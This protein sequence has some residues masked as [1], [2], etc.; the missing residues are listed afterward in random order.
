MET[1][2]GLL[3]QALRFLLGI[4]ILA[5]SYLNL[6]CTNLVVGLLIS[7]FFFGTGG[8]GY[9]PIHHYFGKI[10]KKSKKSRKKGKT[11]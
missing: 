4:A 11:I 9:C 10:T 7:A 2:L 8:I 6:C 5:Y 1:N 3:E